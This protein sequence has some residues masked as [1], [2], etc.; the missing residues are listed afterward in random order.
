MEDKKRSVDVRGRSM[1]LIRVFMW[2]E[3]NRKSYSPAPDNLGGMR[4]KK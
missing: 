3:W 4:M 1:T 2:E